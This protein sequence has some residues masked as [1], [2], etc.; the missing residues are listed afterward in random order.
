MRIFLLLTESLIIV[1]IILSKSIINKK[2][3]INHYFCF[4]LGF[5]YYAVL[6]LLIYELNPSFDDFAYRTLQKRYSGIDSSDIVKYI[7]ISFLLYM[8]FILGSEMKKGEFLFADKTAEHTSFLFSEKLFT[9]PVLIIAV[10]LVFWNSTFLFKGYTGK[11]NVNKGAISAFTIMIVSILLFYIFS[12]PN[13]IRFRKF[14]Y[15]KWGVLFCVFSFLLLTMG[16]RLYVVTCVFALMISYSIYTSK[17]ISLKNA[18][19]IFGGLLFVAGLIGVLRRKTGF[20]IDRVFFNILQE[21]IYTSY[22]LVSY[23]SKNKINKAFS[24]PSITISGFINLVPYRV[25]PDKISYIK[26]VFSLGEGIESPLGATHFFTS[27]I[28]D[29]GI[30]GAIIFFF[31]LGRYISSLIRKNSYFTKTVYCLLSA[32]LMFTIFRDSIPIAFTKN[33]FEFSIVLPYIMKMLNSLFE[34]RKGVNI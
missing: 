33:I 18:L 17:G 7:V 34:K 30:I 28:L 2:L 13:R 23:I 11:T 12:C 24:F 22:S 3:V 25:F 15:S 26:D 21:P 19:V 16:G 5:F 27:Y 20:E 6:P 14:F 1:Y 31:L 32:N 4:S 9:F 8:S 29:Y 10:I